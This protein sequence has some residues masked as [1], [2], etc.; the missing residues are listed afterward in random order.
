M[1]AELRAMLAPCPDAA[2]KLWPVGKAVGNVRNTGR[3]EL[4]EE[5]KL[6]EALPL[7][8]LNLTGSSA[9]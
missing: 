3:E 6:T 4:A 9:N 7:M 2:L 5:I 1:L 8:A